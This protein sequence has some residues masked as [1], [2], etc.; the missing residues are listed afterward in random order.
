[1]VVDDASHDAT[2][3]ICHACSIHEPR[4]KLLA[5]S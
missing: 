4:V 1:V 5:A 2:P 3:E